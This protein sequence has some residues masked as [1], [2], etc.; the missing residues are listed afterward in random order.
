MICPYCGI[1]I[2]VDWAEDAMMIPS[3][4]DEEDEGYG[5]LYGF[6]PECNGYI[7]L[8]QK[9]NEYEYSTHT[10]RGYLNNVIMQ[11]QVYPKFIYKK[12][13]DPSVPKK[14]CELFREAE[15]V[16]NL[17]PRAS[18]TL[19][20]Y[21]LQMILHEELKIK[22]KNLE[23]EIKELENYSNIPST[24]ITMLQVM[25]RV[26]NFGAHPK[27]STNSNEIIDVEIGEADIM[28]DLI[29]EL[30]DYLFIKPQRQKDFLQSIKEKYN[31]EIEDKVNK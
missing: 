10:H 21:L 28:L 20:R 16:L 17:S 26:A 25:R 1:G 19:S 9:G 18:A 30:F 23:E 24:L 31:I 7:I 27:K 29:N 6:C 2:N 15:S 14:Y 4:Q 8:V 5:Q 13:L 11:E 22:K 12:N 3:E